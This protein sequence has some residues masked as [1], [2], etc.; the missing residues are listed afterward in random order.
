MGTI[1]FRGFKSDNGLTLERYMFFTSG[2]ETICLVKTRNEQGILKF[3][4]AVIDG[5]NEKEDINMTMLYGSPVN[6]D[7]ILEFFVK[8][9]LEEPPT[10][11]AEE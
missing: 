1:S 7:L 9:R 11:D 6:P 5:N 8:D 2:A 10:I 3:Y 4:I